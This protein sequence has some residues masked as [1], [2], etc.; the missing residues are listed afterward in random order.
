MPLPLV[1]ELS[2]TKL[3]IFFPVLRSPEPQELILTSSGLCSRIVQHYFS[4]F[5]HKI[6]II[7]T[8]WKVLMKNSSDLSLGRGPESKSVEFCEVPPLV[9]EI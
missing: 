3:G 2:Y 9:V 1:V 4:S 6:A 8:P 5:K 7:S